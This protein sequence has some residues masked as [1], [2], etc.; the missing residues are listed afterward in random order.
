MAVSAS[1]SDW[2]MK[3]HEGL[4]DNQL[5][6]DSTPSLIIILFNNFG[7]FSDNHNVYIHTIHVQFSCK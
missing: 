6:S 7:Q 4:S 1:A 3:F 2:L 5:R